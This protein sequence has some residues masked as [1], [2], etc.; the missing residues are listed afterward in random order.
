MPQNDN[1]GEVCRAAY[2][3][4]ASEPAV[5]FKHGT[6]RFNAVCL[7]TFPSADYIL[8]IV[9]KYDKK[10]SIKPGGSDVFNAVRWSSLNP[11]KRKPKCI[12]GQEFYSRVIELMQWDKKCNY[13][14]FGKAARDDDG[15][16]ISF[17]LNSALIYRPDEY[18]RMSRMPEYPEEWG[19]GFGVS[20]EQHKSNPLFR[21]FDAD[22]EINIE[23]EKQLEEIEE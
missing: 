7:K 19:D 1:T 2:F 5:I 22:T 17:D 6:V 16:F 10:L 11:E 15:I 3:A 21:R 12:T 14:L 13:K 4:N 9:Y 8:F 20:M 18:G 23:Q